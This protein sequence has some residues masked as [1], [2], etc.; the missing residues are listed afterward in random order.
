VWQKPQKKFKKGAKKNAKNQ[1]P[2][3]RTIAP[4]KSDDK[5]SNAVEVCYWCFLIYMFIRDKFILKKCFKCPSGYW[6][7]W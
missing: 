5:A 3:G 1:K 4:K 7:Q 6:Q 2:V